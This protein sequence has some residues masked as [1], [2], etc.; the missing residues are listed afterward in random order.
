MM[1]NYSQKIY[2][3]MEDYVN[4]EQYKALNELG[5]D[6]WSRE[7]KAEKYDIKEKTLKFED[8]IGYRKVLVYED[9]SLEELYFLPTLTQTAKWLREVKGIIICI[10]P[11]FYRNKRPLMGYDYH[12]FNKDDGWYSYIESETVYDTYEQSLSAGIDKALELL[13]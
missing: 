1:Q 2:I 4:I 10:E 9:S 8:R 12:L 13:K 11:G 6:R 5:F 7:T 3:D